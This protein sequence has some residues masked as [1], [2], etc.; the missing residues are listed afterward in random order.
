MRILLL[1]LV[2]GALFACGQPGTTDGTGDNGASS[3]VVVELPLRRGFYVMSDTACGN[4][5]N[6]TLLLIR[7]AGVNGAH[8]AC[9][10]ESIE[11]TGPT[12]YRAAITCRYIQG[13][14]PEASTNV[15]EIPDSAQFT[16]GTED[17]DYRSHYRYCEQS[18]LPE[19]WRDNDVSDLVDEGAGP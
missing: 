17:S 3:G 1:S 11:Q 18:S 13:G 16:Y 10:F 7:R 14:E 8:A 19:P 12:S 5:S 4:A 6:A 15:Y 9:D 2:A